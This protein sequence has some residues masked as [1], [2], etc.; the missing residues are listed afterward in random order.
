ML[1][2]LVI[3]LLLVIGLGLVILLMLMNDIDSMFIS[4]SGGTDRV[5]Y[6]IVVIFYNSVSL[7]SFNKLLCIYNQADVAP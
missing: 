5:V 7:T 6:C 1:L 4:L 3:G 2:G